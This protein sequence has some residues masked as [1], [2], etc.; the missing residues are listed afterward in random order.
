MRISGLIEN[1]IVD[2][3]NGICVSLWTQGCPHHCKN[4]HNPHTWDFN[5]GKEFDLEELIKEIISLI[6][7][8]NIK[9]NF[10]VLGGEPLC[11]E[12][13]ENVLYVIKRVKEIYP[14]IKVYIWTGYVKEE[15]SKDDDLFKLADVIIDGKYDENLRDITLPLRGSSNQRVLRKENNFG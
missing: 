13:K 12:N 14:D 4:C 2:T 10:S 7:K 9:R 8:N 15:F 5:G 1:D 6:N 3:E 11:P